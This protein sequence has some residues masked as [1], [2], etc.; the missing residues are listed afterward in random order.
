MSDVIA[1]EHYVWQHGGRGR[2]A[3]ITDGP[4][5]HRAQT[6][7]HG[8]RRRE[9]VHHA[10]GSQ[11]LEQAREE[12]PQG[13]RFGEL[14]TVTRGDKMTALLPGYWLRWSIPC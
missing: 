14:P 7:P 8:R 13:F 3:N 4:G 5:E 11:S 1:D 10:V 9:E 6:T 12:W 2:R